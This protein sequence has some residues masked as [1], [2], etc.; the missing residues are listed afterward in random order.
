M[1]KF[2]KLIVV[3]IGIS[4]CILF[5]LLSN[6]IKEKFQTISAVTYSQ[7]TITNYNNYQSKNKINVDELQKLGV[8]ESDVNSFISSGTWPWSSGF[9]AAMNQVLIN[10]PNQ[11]LSTINSTISNLQKEFP[12]QYYIDITS[13]FYALGFLNI[14]K[15][16]KISCNVDSSGQS[17]GDTLF[18][19]DDNGNVTST[20]VANSQ[21]PTLIPGFTFLNQPCNPCNLFN[22]DFSCPYAYPDNTGQTVYQGFVMDYIWD[23]NDNL[24]S[25]ND[26]SGT[27]MDTSGGS[28]D[29]SGESVDSSGVSV[30][31]FINDVSQLFNKYFG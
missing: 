11:D 31:G 28:N 14:A 18:T 5:L 7:T 10:T 1:K 24:S 2:K 8:P 19:L 13:A 25:T 3:F 30:N 20:S 21:L 29:S 9:T 12:E 6:K 22:R 23:I 27:S 16:K 15:S 17:T 4:I 26:S